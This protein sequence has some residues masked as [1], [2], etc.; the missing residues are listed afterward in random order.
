MSLIIIMTEPNTER[1]APYK[2]TPKPKLRKHGPNADSV[3]I[4]ENHRT[5][6][7]VMLARNSGM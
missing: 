4:A 1:N 2:A 5:P 6:S 3:L 7:G